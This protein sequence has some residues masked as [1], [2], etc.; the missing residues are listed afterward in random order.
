VTRPGVR[1]AVRTGDADRAAGRV[2]GPNVFRTPQPRLTIQPVSRA[3]GRD[4]QPP[5]TSAGTPRRQDREPWSSTWNTERAAPLAYPPARAT[6]ASRLGLARLNPR[7]TPVAEGGRGTPPAPD[8]CLPR[9]AGSRIRPGAASHAADGGFCA[10][11]GAGRVRRASASDGRWYADCASWLRSP[12]PRGTGRA[13]LPRL[14]SLPRVGGGIRT[15]HPAAG[16]LPWA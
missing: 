6:P 16:L 7:A 1:A 12:V 11:H 15:W 13:H 8:R 5:A 10:G 2:A 9:P 3:A 14:P 4:P